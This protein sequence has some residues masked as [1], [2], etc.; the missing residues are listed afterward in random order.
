MNNYLK[1]YS[2]F[3]LFFCL[4][5]LPSMLVTAMSQ[6]WVNGFKRDASGNL[7]ITCRST[8]APGDRIVSGFWRD[9]NGNLTVNNCGVVPISTPTPTPTPGPTSTPVNPGPTVQTV[10]YGWGYAGVSTSI[11]IA[12]QALWVKFAYQGANNVQYQQGGIKTIAYSNWNICYPTDNPQT[13][14]WEI[15]P[16]SVC[17]ADASGNGGQWHSYS[18]SKCTSTY[19]SQD[20]LNCSGQPIHDPNYGGG[21][22]NAPYNSLTNYW[23]VAKDRTGATVAENYIFGDDTGSNTGSN[24]GGVPCNN[25][26]SYS[27]ALWVTQ[28]NQGQ[29]ALAFNVPVFINGINAEAGSLLPTDLANIV[30]ATTLQGMMCEGCFITSSDTPDTTSNWTNDENGCLEIIAYSKACWVYASKVGAITGTSSA[31]LR[32]YAFASF[33]LTYNNPYSMFQ[34]A[35][36]GLTDAMPVMPEEQLVPINPQ[37]IP[38]TVSDLVTG[39]GY[40][41]SWTDCFWQSHDIGQC[42][43]AVN[44]HS[45]G[46]MT[47]PTTGYTHSMVIPAG[48]STS[49]IVGGGQNQVV[50]TGSV[51]STLTPGTAEIIFP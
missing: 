23:N 16:N 26:G 24:W 20:A 31:S 22:I 12:T 34:Y 36:S 37:Q 15:A 38:A 1:A 43:V 51:S 11:P 6:S 41:R 32:M 4:V 35:I 3:V 5:L 2:L 21:Y 29:S 10:V 46:N 9:S 47:V 39:G 45:S 28:E 48:N 25:S 30:N 33:L 42:A 7:M 14:F 8:P 17:V 40:F 49:D 19:V 18:T 50:L 44:S 27:G 13:C